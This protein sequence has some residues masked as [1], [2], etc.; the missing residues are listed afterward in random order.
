MA[1]KRRRS[2][3]PEVFLTKINN[4][5]GVS[6]YRKGQIIFSQGDSADAV[7]YVQKGKVKLTVVSEQGKEAVIA[8]LSTGDF[9]GEGCL[10][11]QAQRIATVTAM[12]D[13]VIARLERPAII[14][15]IHQEPAFAELNRPGFFGGHFV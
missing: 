11:G 1:P 12:M 15:V 8:I 10:A 5:H 2:F 3:D 14:E 7:F 6:K 9:F 13:A 4:G